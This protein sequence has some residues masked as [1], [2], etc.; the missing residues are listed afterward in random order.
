MLN[1]FKFYVLKDLLLWSMMV[2]VLLYQSFKNKTT[3]I[4]LAASSKRDSDSPI[5]LYEVCLICFQ[6]SPEAIL[7]YIFSHSSGLLLLG[8]R[9]HICSN[10]MGHISHLD[11]L[12]PFPLTSVKFHKRIEGNVSPKRN[13]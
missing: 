4:P 5:H 11:P 8:F 13:S 2:F 10:L 6:C 1:L 7:S 9:V 3:F 12:M